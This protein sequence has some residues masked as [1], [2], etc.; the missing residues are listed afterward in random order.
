MSNTLDNMKIHS[1][2]LAKKYFGDSINFYVN[3][4]PLESAPSIIIEITDG[5]VKILRQGEVK[6]KI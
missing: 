3:E 6:I 5:K 2:V 4:G 1:S